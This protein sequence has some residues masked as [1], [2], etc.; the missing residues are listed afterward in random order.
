LSN[1]TVIVPPSLR[2]FVG[3]KTHDR[4]EAATVRQALEAFAAG[5]ASLRGYLFDKDD[6]L[7]RFVRVFVDGKP[8]SVRPGR[9]EPVSEGAEMTILLALAGG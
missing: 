6:G 7:R 1:V 8:A 2:K 5:S 9:E 3:G 4:V